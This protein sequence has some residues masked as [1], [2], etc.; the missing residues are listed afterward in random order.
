MTSKVMANLNSRLKRMGEV[1]LVVLYLC[2][3]LLTIGK[4][5][6]FVA[7]LLVELPDSDRTFEVSG[8]G[9][10]KK[11]AESEAALQACR[12]LDAYGALHKSQGKKKR[13]LKHDF[14]DD[15]DDYYDRT[16]SSVHA[17]K[18]KE[19]TTEE[20]ETVET[21][22]SLLARQYELEYQLMQLEEAVAADANQNNA[23]NDE[24]DS[25][26]AYISEV[27]TQMHQDQQQTQRRELERCRAE[28]VR[29]KELVEIAKPADAA[30]RRSIAQPS[31]QS[32][33]APATPSIQ[34][35]GLQLK[36]N[37]AEADLK[38]NQNKQASAVTA[39]ARVAGPSLP[40]SSHLLSQR[41]PEP[42]QEVEDDVTEWLPP[43]GQ[44]GDG[45]TALNKKLGY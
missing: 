11:D 10:R 9:G 30:L 23:G 7:R 45:T 12:Y 29:V 8:M 4:A 19:G 21:Y 16:N 35:F 37:Q 43:V 14:E 44:T 28:L 2:Q 39:K 17:K 31:L 22:E 38:P 24:N 3:R 25:L 1:N 15:D 40:P 32:N 6:Q 18:P 27:T 5:K 36:P 33:P 26:D 20:T 13:R 41:Q 34:R 42:S